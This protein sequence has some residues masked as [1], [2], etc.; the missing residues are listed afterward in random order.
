MDFALQNELA[1]IEPLRISMM[2][3]IRITRIEAEYH[4]LAVSQNISERNG[5]QSDRRSTR[6]HDWTCWMVF[7]LIPRRLAIRVPTHQAIASRIKHARVALT[8]VVADTF[9]GHELKIG[10]S[11]VMHNMGIGANAIL[12]QVAKGVVRGKNN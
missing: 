9:R 5:I 12:F 10:R 3:S 2:R 6:H 4:E 11:S 7:D 8:G 1:V